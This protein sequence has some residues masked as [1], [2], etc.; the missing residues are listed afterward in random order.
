MLLVVGAQATII[1]AA[2]MRFGVEGIGHFRR[3]IIV[4]DVFVIFGIIGNQD[5]TVAVFW[6]TL[7][8]KNIVFLKNYFGINAL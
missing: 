7:Q 1:R 8:H 2:I 6:A 3:L 4:S 5:F